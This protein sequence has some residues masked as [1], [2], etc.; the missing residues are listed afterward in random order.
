MTLLRILI[1]IELGNMKYA[2]VTSTLLSLHVAF[3]S[4]RNMVVRAS[5]RNKINVNTPVMSFKSLAN[6]FYLKLKFFVFR[7]LN[8]LKRI[9]KYFMHKQKLRFLSNLLNFFLNNEDI[10]RRLEHLFVC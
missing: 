3:L 9:K 1:E 2:F 4:N 8:Y 7:N 6:E 10:K 5:C